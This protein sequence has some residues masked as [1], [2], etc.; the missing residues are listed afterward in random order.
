MFITFYYINSPIMHCIDIFNIFPG[1]PLFC[2]GVNFPISEIPDYLIGKIMI[3]I[4]III[5]RA[6]VPRIRFN[7]FTLD[8]DSLY[9]NCLHVFVESR[10]L[11]RC[12]PRYLQLQLHL[13]SN[14]SSPQQIFDQCS[15]ALGQRV[16]LP[17]SR[18]T[19][20]HQNV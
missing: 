6:T 5:A 10:C 16:P 2:R 19:T 14:S 12:T 20:N 17:F 9:I 1:R 7:S 4:I 18:R 13:L 11:S 3:L 8:D 15:H